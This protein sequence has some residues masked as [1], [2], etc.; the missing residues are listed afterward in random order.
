VEPL[1]SLGRSRLPAAVSIERSGRNSRLAR[2]AMQSPHVAL[3]RPYH[4][5]DLQ[6]SKQYRTTHGWVVHR[7]FIQARRDTQPAWASN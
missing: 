1:P 5:Q 4:L 2:P 7:L 6:V 3:L